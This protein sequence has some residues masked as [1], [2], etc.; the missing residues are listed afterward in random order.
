VT[1]PLDD[2]AIVR[3]FSE[4]RAWSREGVR[5]PLPTPNASGDVSGSALRDAHAVGSIPPALAAVLAQRPSLVNRIVEVVLD[6]SWEPHPGRVLEVRAPSP[7]VARTY[8]V[9]PSHLTL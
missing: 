4:V 6:A 3:L 1:T 8:S 9:G 5:A 7:W 2:D